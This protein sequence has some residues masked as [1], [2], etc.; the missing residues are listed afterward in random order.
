MR[1]LAA[2]VCPAVLACALALAGASGC[3][4]MDPSYPARPIDASPR[5]RAERPDA[6][7]ATA[8]EAGAHLADATIDSA[9]RPDLAAPTDAA[10]PRRDLAP[11]PASAPPATWQE[12]WFEHD[13]TLALFAHDEHVAVYLDADVD[14]AD[15]AWILPFMSRLWQYSQKTYGGAP[16]PDPRLYSIHHQGRYLGAH[17]ATYYDDTHDGRNA[18][19]CGPGPWRDG[20]FELPVRAVAQLIARANNGSRG[21]PLSNVWAEGKWAEIFQYDAYRALGLMGE[22]ERLFER[23]STASANLPRRDT[24][25]FRDWFYPLWKDHGGALVFARFFQLLGRDFP[26]DATGR[27]RRPLNWGEYVH[28]TSGAAGRDLTALATAAFGWPARW[29]A[30]LVRARA[31]F[32]GVIYTPR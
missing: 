31:E 4:G 18:T 5:P 10:E 12:H 29:Q 1:P 26:R 25:W 3:A 27:Y 20:S 21:S 8:V 23:Y 14:R 6:S 15:V 22:S 13:Q 16:G 30:E 24:Y 7:D 19:D 28:F 9:I 32:P 2:S 17:A 11:S